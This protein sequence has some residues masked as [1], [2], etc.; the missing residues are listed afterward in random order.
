MRNDLSDIQIRLADINSRVAPVFEEN[1]RL[2]AALGKAIT[3]ILAMAAFGALAFIAIA[4]TEQSL[5]ER[6]V[7]N[8]EQI[9]H[10]R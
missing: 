1:S 3:L 7:I 8:Q 9:A 5:K 6:A 2:H 4:P 10:A